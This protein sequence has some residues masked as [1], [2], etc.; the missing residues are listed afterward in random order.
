MALV[1]LSIAFV[2]GIY[3][4]SRAVLPL[5]LVLPLIFVALV[6]AL[7]W[8]RHH[9]L[10]LGGLC[11]ILVLCG[12]LRFQ[13]VPT[14][15]ALQ[16]Y[17]GQGAVDIVGVVAEDPEPR[18]SSTTLRLS[19][20]EIRVEGEWKEVSGA[21]LVRTTRYPTYDYGD[22]LQ[23]S[24]E[25]EE[26]PQFDDFDYRAYLAREGI[27]S[28]IY[29]PQIDFLDGGHGHQP[30]QSIYSFRNRMAEAMEESLP[31][32]QGAVAEAL[33]LGIRSNVPPS[34]YQDFQRSGTAHLLAISGLHMAIVAGILL[35]ISVSLFGRRRP[36][37]FV[38]TLSALWFYALL[39]GMSP[40]VTRAAIM[41][42]VFL[43]AAYL[44]R[45]RSVI[46][47]LAFAGAVMVAINPQILWQVSF[48]LSFAAVAG[49][50]LLG[51]IFQQWGTRIRAPTIVVDSFSVTL[52]AILAT[53]PL[54]AYYF[55]Y[56]SLVGLPATFLALPALPAVIVLSAV[57][58]LI[59]L[60]ALPLAQVIGWVD[61]LFLGYMTGVVKLF[62]AAPWSSV[63]V[64]GMDVS[65]VVLYYALL[66][67]A[68]WLGTRRQRLFSRVKV[69][70]RGIA[71]GATSFARKFPAPWVL[72]PLLVIAILVWAAA[73]AAPSGDKLTVSFL[74]V[75]Q[76]DAILIQRGSQQVLVDGGPSP[77]KICLELGE[78]LPF[79]DKTIELV[80]LTHPQDDHLL[81]LVE[82]LSRYKVGQ[83]LEPGFE[84]DTPAYREWL[85]LIEEKDIDRTIAHAGQQVELGNGITIEVLHPQEEFLEG[86]NS[87]VNEN[88]I[89]LRLVR[90]EV[91][92][93][94]T[95]DIEEEAEWQLLHQHG[96]E[97]K[98]TVLKVAHHGSATSTTPSFLV[99]VSPQ[100]A[101]IS[102]SEDNRFG[103][104]SAEVMARLNERL[105]GDNVYLTAESGTITFTT[106][107]ERLWLKTER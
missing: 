1:Y 34:T 5:S 103:H 93:L 27:Y 65:L 83:I 42:S 37:Y 26:P 91:S 46:T 55:G 69:G 73:I 30:L 33:V 78:R 67:G 2:T 43:F 104:P 40:S 51:P 31:E 106:D 74:D 32:P 24:G 22:M 38:V 3:L 25:L 13:A 86:T 60:F 81:G 50:V 72:I 62:A 11:L 89:V 70:G 21:S 63:E 20:R 44:G 79:W 94:L 8:R 85:R 39:A 41:V 102:V 54:I 58:G 9:I 98:V 84:Q 14:G 18:D 16:S 77:E 23:V 88:S 7:S 71:M 10:L 49:L 100:V 48:Q 101:V 68:L 76:G 53:L 28:T 19:A 82:V 47:A 4:G 87:D 97:L 12:A 57:V 36:T 52:A 35:S 105:G 99:A 56:V 59:G 95:G 92:F 15:D 6:I 107:G 61:W 96:I 90:D 66:G 80:V 64:G 29:Y 17:I 75:G 45:Q